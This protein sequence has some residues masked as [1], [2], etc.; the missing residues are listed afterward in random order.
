MNALA[1]SVENVVVLVGDAVRWDATQ[2]R[3]A[4]EYG[5]TYKTV[6]A[7]LHTPTAFATMFPG[8]H[9]PTHGVS[10]FHRSV[11][12]R[13]DTLLDLDSH[14]A[15]FSTGGANEWIC[16][17]QKLFGTVD[18]TTLRE[19]DPPFVWINRHPGGHSPYGNF[20]ADGDG[21]SVDEYFEQHTQ[22]DDR[23]ESNYQEAINDFVADV[24]ETLTELS[25]RE[26]RDE[27][28]VV[29]T[30]DHGELLGE[31]GHVGHNFLPRPELVYVPTTLVHPEI[32]SE[33]VSDGVA[34]HVD[35]YPTL[36][37]ALGSELPSDLP[38][39]SLLSQGVDADRGRPRRPGHPDKRRGPRS[40]T[41]DGVP[42]S[43][44]RHCQRRNA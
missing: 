3:L 29:V 1:D 27:T 12:S 38:G 43:R 20:G 15:A 31:G 19:A 24:D 35:L 9:P 28:L 18:R 26:I 13:T 10:G 5:R 30:S 21:Q 22:S 40:A 7:S 32:Q 8:R 25:R 17:R 34:R 42:V 41:G 11:P 23:L 16:E 36:L 2:R 37:D 4:A 33:R 39:Q 44:S 6:A 14:E